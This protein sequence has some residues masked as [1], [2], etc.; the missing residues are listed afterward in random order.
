MPNATS[1]SSKTEHFDLKTLPDGFVDLRKMTYGEMLRRR[2]IGSTMRA[3][4]GRGRK[5]GIEFDTDSLEIQHY[6]FSRCIVDHNLEDESG[7]LLNFKNTADIVKLDPQIASEIESL[8]FEM[9][10]PPQDDD[11]DDVPKSGEVSSSDSVPDEATAG[12][13]I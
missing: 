4:Q 3:G 5:A 12:M 9:N 7:K 11:E 6:E 13:G 10:Q 2:D 1:S 8:I